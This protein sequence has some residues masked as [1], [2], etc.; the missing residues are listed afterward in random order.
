MASILRW[1]VISLLHEVGWLPSHLSQEYYF[2]RL[3]WFR[4]FYLRSFV[5][6][7][8]S[9]SPAPFVGSLEAGTPLACDNADEYPF[10]T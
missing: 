10:C 7:V 2:H 8:F 9:K 3:G 4:L 6:S 1:L 5:G